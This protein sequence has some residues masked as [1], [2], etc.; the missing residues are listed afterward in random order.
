MSGCFIENRSNVANDNPRLW[1]DEAA[2][3]NGVRLEF[4]NS[5]W[6]EFGVIGAETLRTDT[7]DIVT[8]LGITQLQ[9]RT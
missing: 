4:S 2:L 7:E 3:G 8:K 1:A 9:D 6:K 5:S